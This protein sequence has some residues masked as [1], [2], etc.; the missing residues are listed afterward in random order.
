[1]TVF[2]LHV[3]MTKTG[4]TTL[5]VTFDEARAILL[6]HGVDYLDVG[7]NHNGIIRTIARGTATFL[8]GETARRLAI[9]K[10]TT[11][12][13]PQVVVDGFRRLLEGA[14][15]PAMVASGQGLYAT[16]G[17]E[18]LDRLKTV[19]AEHFTATKIVVYVREPAG[20]A[21]SRVQELVK[22]G[23]TQAELTALLA[24]G[25]ETSQIV[26][27]YS[28]IQN[29]ID[30]FGRENVDIRIFD[31]SRFVAGDLVA[32]FCTAIGC[33]PDL[34]GKLPV[35]LSN[36]S[37]SAEALHLI[38]AHYN[39][40]EDRLRAEAG[41]PPR[42]P[43]LRSGG[44]LAA[45]REAYRKQSLN[46]AFRQAVKGMRGRRW[47]LPDDV[48]DQVWRASAAELDWLRRTTGEPGLFADPPRRQGEAPATAWTT[49][50]DMAALIE[51]GLEE[52]PARPVRD[53]PRGLVADFRSWW[54]GP[55]GAKRPRA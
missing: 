51:A 38:E 29:Y 7:Q 53:R 39:L 54:G 1:M 40:I 52:K 50:E 14:K 17:P 31:R 4:S 16:L 43:A 8:K 23:F 5:Q 13:D 19:L 25:P 22:H 45:A 24:E 55:S 37:V 2:Y 12:Y 28:R 10:R 47:S 26:P 21:S 6:Q 41:A 3:G 32:D 33:G 48:L 27:R 36:T 35:N 49:Y 11:D 42:D 44:G 15:A 20:W 46:A 30:A 9:P 18:D 34:A